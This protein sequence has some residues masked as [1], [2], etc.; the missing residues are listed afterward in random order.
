M[1]DKFS[2]LYLRARKPVLAFFAIV[3]AVVVFEGGAGREVAGAVVEF[4]RYVSI[5]APIAGAVGRARADS[6]DGGTR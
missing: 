6:T 3:T 5:A 4:C 1:K 2:A